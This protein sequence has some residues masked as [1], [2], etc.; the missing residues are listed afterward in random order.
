[1]KKFI[2]I[3][4]MSFLSFAS[5]AQDTYPHFLVEN[6]KQTVVFTLEQAQKIDNDQQLLAQFRQLGADMNSVDSACVKVVD[7]QGKEIAGLKTEIAG[8]KSLGATKD[9]DIV[10]LKVQ[11][12]EYTKKEA[13]S[14]KESDA[15]DLI[16]VEKDSQI[17][18]Q[19]NQKIAAFIGAGAA[20]IALVLSLLHG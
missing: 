20:A 12:A 3:V 8:L 17:K 16:I 19:R 6:G 14:K 7:A 9:K 2:L 18:K 11:I 13:L 10:N 4:I 5:N 1:M 15:K